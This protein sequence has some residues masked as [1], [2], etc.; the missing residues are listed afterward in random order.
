[1]LKLVT[2]EAEIIKY[3]KVLETTL[4]KELSSKKEIRM[5]FPS[6]NWVDEVNYNSDIWYST[7]F[8]D[9]ENKIS[10]FWNGFGLSSESQFNTDKSNNIAVEINIAKKGISRS[11]RGSFVIDDST[12]EVMLIHRGRVNGFTKEEFNDWYPEQF[13]SIY[14]DDGNN[15]EKVIVIAVITSS[16]FIEKLTDFVKNVAKFK[17]L[18]KIRALSDKKLDEI[19][20][21]LENKKPATR[22][23]AKTE[24]QRSEYLVEFAK[25]QAQG[26]CRLCKCDAPFKKEN[27]EAYLEIHHVKWLSRDGYDS[28]K[29]VVALC[30]N[31]HRKMHSLNLAED[32]AELT[33]IAKSQQ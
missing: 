12:D 19:I 17:E 32:V 29:N 31:C 9:K 5:G 13:T 27:G 28:P 16:D 14:D 23:V 3:Q 1:M 25:R 10:R 33:K 7:F 26:K 21:T 2:K 6:G 30:P 11:V 22:I 24:F 18:A 4:K 8:I 15:E 20:R